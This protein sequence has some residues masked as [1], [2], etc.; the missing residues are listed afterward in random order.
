VVVLSDDSVDGISSGMV[1]HSGTMLNFA[2]AL[3]EIGS[4]YYAGQDDLTAYTQI[5]REVG[6]REPNTSQRQRMDTL[7]ENFLKRIEAA[8]KMTRDC[9]MEIENA[10]LRLDDAKAFTHELEILVKYDGILSKELLDSGGNPAGNYIGLDEPS[11]LTGSQGQANL[12]LLQGRLSAL[13]KEIALS[14]PSN[15]RSV[16]AMAPFSMRG[17]EGET[18]LLAFINESAL[19]SLSGNPNLSLVERA[20]LDAVRAEKNLLR[21]LDTDAAIEVGKLLGAQ[22]MI[23]GQ[24]IPMSTQVIIF[25]RVIHVETGEIVSAAQVFVERSIIGELL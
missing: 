14:F 20:R 7:K 11:P 21:L 10:K 16:A 8:I 2:K 6:D 3:V 15:R 17:V 24:V 9:R 4:L 5:E 22:Y 25:G 12:N 23:T 18:P 19:V 13:Y 1:L